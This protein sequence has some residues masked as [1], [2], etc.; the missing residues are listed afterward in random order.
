MSSPR[1]GL[2]LGAG[3]ARG[4]S[5]IGVLRGLLNAG[6]H[7]HIITG[8]SIGAVVGAMY[9][10]R[11]DVDWIEDRFRKLL[12]SEPFRR[13][14]IEWVKADAPGA[15]PAFFQW[16]SKLMQNRWILRLS[17][18]ALGTAKIERLRRVI[19][20]L[21]PEERFEDLSLPFACL[22]TNLYTGQPYTFREG[23]LTEALCAT[24]SIP[25]YLEPVRKD[26]TLLVDGAVYQPVPIALARKLGADFTIAVD[27]SLKIFNPLE[28]RNILSLVGRAAAISSARLASAGL[29]EADIVLKPD[30]LNLHWTQFDH[31]DELVA[32][33]EL[34][35]SEQITRLKEKLAAR[36]GIRGLLS[37]LRRRTPADNGLD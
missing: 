22:A 6:I 33:G 8:A 12:A 35:V 18:T 15:E 21:V 4:L 1:I 37:K 3:G 5:H 30:T 36:K 27:V 17:M 10:A 23:D 26:E 11:Q 29:T 19:E 14:G 32:N 9:A 34:A 28:E 13:S 16:A 2:V 31:L 7:P 25:G 24:G 20:F